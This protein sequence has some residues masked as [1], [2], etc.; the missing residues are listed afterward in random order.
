[1]Q[2]E[3]RE[4]ILLPLQRMQ[5]EGGGGRGQDGGVRG[6]VGG[7]V[8]GGETREGIALVLQTT[9]Q[10]GEQSGLRQRRM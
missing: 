6:A 7:G 1:M 9:Q 10:E 8:G 2:K 3:T 4:G 5:R